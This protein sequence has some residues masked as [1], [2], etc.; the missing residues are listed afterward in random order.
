MGSDRKL[1]VIGLDGATFALIKPWAEEGKLPY[2]KRLMEEALWR[3]IH[4]LLIP[5]S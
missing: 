1:C 2:F 3:F 4:D 5:R